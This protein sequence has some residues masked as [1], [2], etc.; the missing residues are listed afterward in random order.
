M[1][2]GTGT[3]ETKRAG[4]TSPE[5]GAQSALLQHLPLIATISAFGFLAIRVGR[6]SRS[7]PGTTLTLLTTAGLASVL[8][9]TL[10]TFIPTLAL[11]TLVVLNSLL[12]RDDLSESRRRWFSTATFIIVPVSVLVLPWFTALLIGLVEIFYSVQAIRRRKRRRDGREDPAGAEKSWAVVDWVAVATGA[13]VSLFSSDALWLPA[14]IVGLSTGQSEVAF[15]LETDATWTTLMLEEG[16]SIQIV[17]TEIVESRTV[18]NLHGAGTQSLADIIDSDSSD[19]P[20][21]SDPDGE[22]LPSESSSSSPPTGVTP[23][24]SPQEPP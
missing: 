7:D 5:V 22:T 18:C 21:C 8:V 13:F 23:P 16:R 12:R 2:N 10:I 1:A 3:D 19:N 11:A 24:I 20:T 15:V 14:E 17:R 4:S 6:V 9:G